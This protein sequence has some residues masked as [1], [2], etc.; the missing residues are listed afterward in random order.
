M[1]LG[2]S[3]SMSLPTISTEDRRTVPAWVDP[4]PTAAG[5]VAI[6]AGMLV[7]LGW[8]QDVT[9]LKSLNTAVSM[10]VN[11][12]VLVIGLGTALILVGRQL[13]RPAMVVLALTATVALLMSAEYAFGV[14]LGIDELVVND[15]STVNPGRTSP[16]TLAGVL[17]LCAALVVISGGGRVR[18]FVGQALAIAAFVLATVWVAGYLYDV[19]RL[20]TALD[21]VTGTALHTA[22]SLVAICLG[23][24]AL[25]PTEGMMRPVLAATGPARQTRLLLLAS[26]LVPLLIGRLRLQGELAGWYDGRT[27]LAI[28]ATA[29]VTIFGLLVQL[30]ATTL[31]RAEARRQAADAALAEARRI[32]QEILDRSPAV[33]AAKDLDGRFV[34]A[35]RAFAELLD[36]DGPADIVGR[37][38]EDFVD[39]DSA[40]AFQSVDRL[41]AETGEPQELEEV[42]PTPDGRRRHFDSVKFP[43][44]DPEGRV[45]AVGLIG[46]DVSERR[47]AERERERFRERVAQADRMES[48]GQLA[49][50]VAHDFNNLLG[51]ILNYAALIQSELPGDA[52]GPDTSVQQDLEAIISAAERAAGLSRQLLTFAR[53]DA[54]GLTVVDV[55]GLV[56]GLAELL[57]RTFPENVRLETRLD[58]A[59]PL[60]HADPSR[61]EQLVMNLAVNARDAMPDGG[62]LIIETHREDLPGGLESGL[63]PGSYLKLAVSDDGT[64]MPSEVRERAFEPFFTTKSRGSG[65][66][67]GLSTAY[68]I[69]NQ[70][71]GQITIYSEPGHGTSVQL[72][73][74]AA[75]LAT[76]APAAVGSGEQGP[77]DE[78]RSATVL[79]VE[80]EAMLRE[81]V[82]RVL[83]R[84]GFQVVE[85]ADA[86]E[87]EELVADGCRPD[88][89]LTDVILPGRSGPQLAASL[90][91]DRPALPVL[92]ASGYTAAA[93]EAHDLPAQPYTLVEKPF[94]LDRLIAEVRA[95]LTAGRRQA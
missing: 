18:A 37:R 17:G 94:A 11:T 33:I 31:A 34:L 10:K 58:A 41:V 74:P 60:V 30:S 46:T 23:V 9:L 87:A 69:V 15:P 29:N 1:P 32:Q 78:L 63:A 85:A 38:D 61:I 12:A 77:G 36:R 95:L 55:N 44:L 40:A 82:R 64:G 42:V 16:S 24:L 14:D 54:T 57:R 28:F 53:H 3:A 27:G 84:A 86:E 49:G 92:F 90:R 56:G 83:D 39:P 88:L 68:G 50:G 79:L 19:P 25:R 80:D 48:L 52:G 21:N 89:L 70:L 73:L 71:D 75:E 66:G 65:T 72:H 6:T 47:A 8:A 35:N 2:A 45:L 81:A 13:V 5:L 4:V 51:V 43:L 67:L 91:R 7:L 93:L 20:Y 59:A 22:L 62:R 26:V 76:A